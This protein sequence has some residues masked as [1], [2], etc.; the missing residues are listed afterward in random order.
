MNPRHLV[1]LLF[2]GSASAAEYP[3]R[4]IGITD[5]DTLTVLAAETTQVKIRSAGIDAPE[6][7]Q[8]SGA[9]AK[10]AAS[11]LAFGKTVT[12]I[13]RDKDRYGRTVTDVSLADG[14][15]LNRE[16]VRN[17]LAWSGPERTLS[18]LGN[19]GTCA[20]IGLFVYRSLCCYIHGGAWRTTDG[21]QSAR[22]FG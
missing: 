1:V 20:L 22:F 19:L 5:G 15:S 21:G 18:K 6:S 4:V 11:D 14:R 2:V 17:G 12:I 9:R 8:D 3:A 10:Q 13:E 7:G 16:M